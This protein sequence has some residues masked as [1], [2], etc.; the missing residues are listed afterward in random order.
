MPARQFKTKYPVVDTDPHFNTVVGSF[1][2]SDW[3]IVAASTAAYPGFIRWLGTVKS[4][5]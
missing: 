1:R 4:Q 3:G 5:L 2:A